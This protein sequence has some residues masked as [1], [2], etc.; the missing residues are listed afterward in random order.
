MA[1]VTV[2]RRLLIGVSVGGVLVF[3]SCSSAGTTTASQPRGIA[4]GTAP[5]PGSHL[6]SDPGAAL[7]KLLGFRAKNQYGMVWD[8]LLPQQQG[9]VSKQAYEGCAVKV[10]TGYE[11]AK[12][13]VKEIH[14]ERIDVPGTSLTLPSKAVTTEQVTKI[15]GRSTM[16]TVTEHLIEAD[17]RW[18]WIMTK[19]ELAT[20][21]PAT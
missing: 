13:T 19:T 21:T 7:E 10:P 11:L 1:E 6:A 20:C 14:D 16:E 3:T 18:R 8:R 5:R 17:G 12:V 4:D 9:L 15:N 2:L